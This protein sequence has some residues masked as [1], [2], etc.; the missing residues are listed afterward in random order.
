MHDSCEVRVWMER[1]QSAHIPYP[2]AGGRTR[3]LC[4]PSRCKDLQGYLLLLDFDRYG[5]HVTYS[6]SLILQD[7]SSAAL[8]TTLK[9]V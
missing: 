5:M 3:S 9:L 6:L 8:G 1:V 4:G 7:L 2:R